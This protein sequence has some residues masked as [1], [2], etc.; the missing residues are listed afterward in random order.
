M[1][2]APERSKTGV[3]GRSAFRR[4][5]LESPNAALQSPP[6]QGVTSNNY[7]H[8]NTQTLLLNKAILY[9]KY[10]I[11]TVSGEIV[12]TAWASSALFRILSGS[13]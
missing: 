7:W 1:F 4:A 2:W 3:L 13:N 12:E 11:Y 8:Q 5:K 10:N 6:G 9:L